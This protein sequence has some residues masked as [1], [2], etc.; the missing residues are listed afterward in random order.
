MK[1]NNKELSTKQL[2]EDTSMIIQICAYLE[3]NKTSLDTAS[4]I[5][6]SILY[7][8]LNSEDANIK[9]CQIILDEITTKINQ[10][11]KHK[12]KQKQEK[13]NE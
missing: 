7:N 1:K 10:I 3:K 12:H 5:S 8:C 9:E 2:E 11:I 13:I 6:M 4:K